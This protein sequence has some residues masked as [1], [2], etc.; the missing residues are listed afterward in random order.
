MGMPN[1]IEDRVVNT[2]LL[3]ALKSSTPPASQNCAN[4]VAN[5]VSLLEN[6]AT[7]AMQA[8]LAAGGAAVFQQLGLD[9]PTA[10]AIAAA[11]SPETFST[12]SN[13]MNPPPGYYD[14]AG[15]VRDHSTEHKIST[16]W[17][18]M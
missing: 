16:C 2:P 1:Y 11:I 14:D 12:L 5:L 17:D 18:M 7:P 3:C 8:A 10:Q 4:D 13:F 6:S 15:N 9:E